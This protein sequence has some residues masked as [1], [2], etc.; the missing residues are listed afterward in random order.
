MHLKLLICL[1]HNDMQFK[2]GGPDPFHLH[3]SLR[4]QIIHVFKTAQL[5]GILIIIFFPPPPPPINNVGLGT[6]P[7]S[8]KNPYVHR[9]KLRLSTRISNTMNMIV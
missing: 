8:P 9:K 7:K 3:I 4:S 6:R 5:M 1:Q 2:W